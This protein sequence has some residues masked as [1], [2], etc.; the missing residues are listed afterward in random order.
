MIL[1]STPTHVY[2]IPD[3]ILDYLKGFLEVKGINA[4]TVYWNIVLN[5]E[6]QQLNKEVIRNPELLDVIPF[7]DITIAIWKWLMKDYKKINELPEN[8]ILSL[9]L[10]IMYLS[11]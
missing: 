3:H 2:H 5:R 10:L 7:D 9:L 4:K 11:V 1:N 8:P 6:F